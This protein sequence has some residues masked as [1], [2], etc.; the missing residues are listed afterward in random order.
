MSNGLLNDLPQDAQKMMDWSWQEIE[1]YYQELIKFNLKADS[2]DSFLQN[3]TRLHDLVDE[4]FNRLYVAKDVNT[5]DKKAQMS[6]QQFLNDIFPK[7]KEAEQKLKT[8]LLESGLQPKDFELPLRRMRTEA[9]IF[10][11]ENLP[12]FVEQQQL[13]M[14]YNKIV[15]SQTV[16]W[17]GEEKTVTQMR[18]YYQD[19]DRV[20][21]ESAWRLVAERQL[22]DRK[23]LNDLWQ[24]LLKLR[25]KIAQNAGFNNYRSFRWQEM[26]R[27]DYTPAD[28]QQFHKAIEETFVPAA[29]G[30]YEKRRKELG[31]KTLRPWDLDVDPLNLPPLQPFSNMDELK[32]KTAT[33]LTKVN[34]KIGAYF[35]TMIKENLLDLDNRKNKAPGGY[36]TSFD[37]VKRPFIF[38][39]AIGIH[40]DVM[41]LLHES[42][43][44]CHSFEAS[45]LPYHQQRS[46][47]L[48]FGEVASMGMELLAA[49]YLAKDE[50]GFYDKVDFVRARKKHLEDIILF[51]PYMAV[52]DGFQHW[53]YENPDQALNPK[54]CDEYWAKLWQRFKKVVDWEGLEDVMVTGWQRKLHIY[55]EP[56]YY[57]EY[58][59]AQ[60]GACQVWAN[61]MKDQSWAIE[62]YL[63]ALALG[64]TKSLPDLFA[65]AGAQFGFGTKI[66][67][68]VVELL[69]E[70]IES[71]ALR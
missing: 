67:K 11:Q 44:A 21:R 39:N 30:I 28:C 33:I 64:G 46:V 29:S 71:F 36:C 41:T 61:A 6:Y 18:V 25:L 63:K 43:H 37:A 8:K 68:P 58:G 52:I 26:T 27:F 49:P 45:R 13:T 55:L 56:F 65:T 40:Q 22:A 51:L 17:E 53:V 47:G 5:E 59:L 34:P 16:Q 14:E 20:R 1:P 32:T 23:A 19:S 57:V 7:L 3:W 42:G 24:R 62:N 4:V 38:M 60:L 10:R 2:V 66:L 50:G 9:A 31:V 48:E 69:V 15:G 35:E 12:L 70:K 54:N